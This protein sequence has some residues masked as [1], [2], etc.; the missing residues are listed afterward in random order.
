MKPLS[1][2]CKSIIAGTA[3]LAAMPA[4]AASEMTTLTIEP[5]TT[6][7]LRNP[8]TGWVMYLGRTWDSDFW[9]ANGYDSMVTS[10][11]DTV[12]VSDYASCAYIR[13][14]WASFEPEEGKY[15]WND[16]DSRLMRLIRSVWDRGMRIAFRVVIDGRDQAQNTPQYVFDAG[17]E[18]YY[19]PKNPGKNYSPYPDDPVFQEKYTKF[20]HAMAREFDDPD[21]VE[22]IDAYSL[23]KWGESHS[24]IYKDNANKEP[25]FEWVVSLATSC[26][27]RVPMLV[28]YH[29]M[30]GDPTDD[31]W[32]AVPENAARLINKA[33]DLGFSLRHDAFGMTGYYQEWEK[34]QA[35][36]WNFTRP[37][38]MEGGWITGAHHR[39]WIDPSG[40]YRQGHAID[41]REGEYKASR[42]AHVNMMDFRINDE[43]R[44]WF[45]EAFP[46]VKKFI[47]EGGYR[48]YPDMISI[49]VSAA[50]GQKVAITHRWNN[51]GWGYCPTNIP[52]WNQRYKV[53]FAL[54]D[55]STLEPVK[56]WADKNT[57]LDLWLKDSPTEYTTHITLDGVKA[58]KYVWAVGLVDVTRGNEIGL[59]I[60]AKDNVT[61]LGWV[62]LSD[63]ILK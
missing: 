52:Q 29:R 22:F 28:H 4:F 12:R 60:A 21:K 11:G 62:K 45:Q 54:L 44:S 59:K 53:G 32:G 16:P 26:F 23:G 48:L 15:A 55:A 13:T 36:K 34:E 56:V 3:L 61:P 49:P 1:T 41:V 33:V 57:R 18:G 2:F 50:R 10:T 7:T 19:D 31:G 17:A 51:L 20:F 38:I 6:S 42:E 40:E 25:V 58:G 30:L 8:L 37:I 63:V 5:D 24:M 35:K 9:T 39:Y 14:S 46:L 43:T 47:A 27:K